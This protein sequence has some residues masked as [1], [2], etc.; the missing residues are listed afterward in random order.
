[1]DASITSRSGKMR[2]LKLRSL[3]I[4]GLNNRLGV[5][6]KKE[7][8]FVLVDH[9]FP[10]LPRKHH[11]VSRGPIHKNNNSFPPDALL[12]KL[13]HHLSHTFSDVPKFV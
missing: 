1:M 10:L 2:I 8:T 11:R 13:K 12:I 4:Y 3:H 7:D 5:E 6:L 9:I